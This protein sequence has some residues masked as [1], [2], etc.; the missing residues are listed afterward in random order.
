MIYSERFIGSEFTGS[1]VRWLDQNGYCQKTRMNH[2]TVTL[3]AIVIAGTAM[4]LAPDVALPLLKGL[5]GAT[6]VGVVAELHK[7]K[8]RKQTK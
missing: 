5:A 6:V 2:K 8:R 7:T 4:H 3:L 1:A